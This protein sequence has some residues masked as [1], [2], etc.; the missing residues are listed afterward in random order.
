[1]TDAVIVFITTASLAEA[2][3]IAAQLVVQRLAA[4]VNILPPMRSI[5]YWQ[6]KIC[7][8]SECLLIA[9]TVTARLAQLIPYV[10]S[11]HSY[12]V[13]EI[14]AFPIVA[15]AA[16]YLQWIQQETFAAPI[17]T[18]VVPPAENHSE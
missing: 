1:M 4:C 3:K 7:H 9:K 12:E 8:E 16:N 2:E 15:G 6:D 10:Q 5:F 18:T 17:E 13:P 11:Q 14:I